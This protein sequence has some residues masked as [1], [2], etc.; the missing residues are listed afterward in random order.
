MIAYQYVDKGEPRL[1]EISV[2]GGCIVE[3]FIGQSC[4][5]SFVCVLDAASTLRTSPHRM[6]NGIVRIDDATVLGICTKNSNQPF[7]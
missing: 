4:T 6:K 3:N 7:E 5:R 2:S 1:K